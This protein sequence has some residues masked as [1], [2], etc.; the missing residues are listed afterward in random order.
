[1]LHHRHFFKTPGRRWL[2]A[3][4]LMAL[5]GCGTPASSRLPPGMKVATHDMVS[6]CQLLSDV[7][8]L[9]NFSGFMADLGLARAR[10]Q[11]IERA[12][13]L[14]ANT[15][16]WGQFSTPYGATSVAGNAYRCP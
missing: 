3:L 14:G 7:H 2:L 5:G 15:I 13:A 4:A 10:R 16:V 9:S 8:G 11:A 6:G 1:M 12:E